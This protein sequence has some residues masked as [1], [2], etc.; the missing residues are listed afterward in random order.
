MRNLLTFLLAAIGLTPAKADTVTYTMTPKGGEFS[1]AFVLTNT[2]ETGGTLFDLFLSI[3]LDISDIDTSTIGTPVGW[4]DPTGGL[5]FFGSNVSPA[6]SFIEWA[7]DASGLYDLKIGASLA[8]FSFLTPEEIGGPITFALNGAT[9]FNTAEPA[10]SVP[11]PLL[12]VWV[13]F[14]SYLACTISKK[15]LRF[16]TKHSAPTRKSPRNRGD[17]EHYQ[18]LES[19]EAA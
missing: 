6:A 9:M 16:A 3:P 19:E 8:G 2:G 10:S 1:Y 18:C 13:L 17:P 12:S 11:E 7:D 5:L 4:G 14:G 15:M